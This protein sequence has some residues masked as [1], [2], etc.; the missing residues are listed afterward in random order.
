MKS[1][2]LAILFFF[3][4]LPEGLASRQI[5]VEVTLAKN[6]L[7]TAKSEFLVEAPTDTVWDVVL[8]Q[9]DQWSEFV[10]RILYS[11]IVTEDQAKKI[12][13]LEN[14][15]W[16]SVVKIAQGEVGPLPQRIQR[17]RPNGWE[18]H[19]L[20]LMDLPW[21]INNRWALQKEIDR[22]DPAMHAYA[23]RFI[24]EKGNLVVAEGY[25]TARPHRQNPNWSVVYY[26]NSYDPGFQV[27]ESLFKPIVRRETRAVLE[28][29]R[30]RAE[31]FTQ[32]EVR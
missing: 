23:R 25:W 28:A 32:R 27:P 15:K 13:E 22:Y 9:I 26:E 31:D 6:R 18:Y 14:L 7:W 2:F 20:L 24:L 21:P 1:I 29:V 10:P 4:L 8:D 30:Q 3:L 12:K 19:K 5:E 17:T 16:E 11:R